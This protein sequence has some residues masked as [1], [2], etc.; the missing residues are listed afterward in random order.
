MEIILQLMYDII[1]DSNQ[2]RL[3]R[4]EL[5]NVKWTCKKQPFSN[6]RDMW[7]K[8]Y[9]ENFHKSE[10]IQCQL[11]NNIWFPMQPLATLKYGIGYY[12]LVI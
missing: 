10:P 1:Q 3:S 7:S 8:N 6:V 2:Q 5:F 12:I 9:L 11:S 4:K